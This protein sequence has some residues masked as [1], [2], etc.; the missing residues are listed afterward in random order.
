MTCVGLVQL[1]VSMLYKAYLIS[2]FLFELLYDLLNVD[3]LSQRMPGMLQ[4]GQNRLCLFRSILP[5]VTKQ[6]G[7]LYYCISTQSMKTI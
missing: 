2:Q 7:M 5:Y 1:S 3:T 4:A 6:Q